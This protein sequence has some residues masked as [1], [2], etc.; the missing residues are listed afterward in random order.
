MLHAPYQL[1]ITHVLP[2]KYEGE[3]LWVGGVWLL[4]SGAVI[5]HPDKFREYV[6]PSYCV[7]AFLAGTQTIYNA[8]TSCQF[9]DVWLAVAVD[10]CVHVNQ[11]VAILWSMDPC[12]QMGSLR[13]ST[14]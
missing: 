2:G 12:P 8:C 3:E 6:L 9:Y 10:G 13:C 11:K 4:C 5:A 7:Q 14:T 1:S